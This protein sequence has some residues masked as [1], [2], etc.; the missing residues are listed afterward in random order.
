MTSDSAR[1][2]LEID[3]TLDFPLG[4]RNATAAFFAITLFPA[5]GLAGNRDLDPRMR[6]VS[7]GAA[8]L[9]IT[10]ILLCQ[11]RASIPALGLAVI[12]YLLLSPLRL[13]ALT[14]LVLATL[15]AIGAVPAMTDL[16]T[17]VNG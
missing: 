5:L 11:S 15:P 4:Y 16:Y 1:S 7:L 17:T 14:W 13:R 10:M 2:V 12:V 9:N 3:G 6:A 8:T